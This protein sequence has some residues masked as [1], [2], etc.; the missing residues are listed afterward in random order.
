ISGPT[1]PAGYNRIFICG[2]PG[3]YTPQCVRSIV[4]TLMT[5]A[6]RR[7]AAEDEV[8][9]MMDLVSQIQ[10]RDSAEEAIRFVIEGILVS[11]NFL[12]RIERDA[13]AAAPAAYPVS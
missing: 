11:P 3:R 13:P 8:N 5:R 4:T 6:Y 12:F 2:E 1:R 9:K 10:K 7:P